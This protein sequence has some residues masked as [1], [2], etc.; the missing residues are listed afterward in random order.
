M[1]SRE[2]FMKRFDDSQIGNVLEAVKDFLGLTWLE[3]E[4]AIRTGDIKLL[5]DRRLERGRP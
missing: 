1:M 2:Y 4:T 5:L 3:L